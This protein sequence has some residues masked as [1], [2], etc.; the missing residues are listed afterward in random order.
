MLS[1]ATS[2]TSLLRREFCPAQP[3][4]NTLGSVP[5]THTPDTHPLRSLPVTVR[6]W[7]E[8]LC[9]KL[10]GDSCMR[11]CMC[12]VPIPLMVHNSAEV[13]SFCP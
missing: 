9:P 3:S 7:R 5:R 1:I 2:F 10:I 4:F 13:C 12:A 6:A 11:M 8:V